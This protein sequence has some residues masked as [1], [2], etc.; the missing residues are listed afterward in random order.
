M[1]NQVSSMMP[2]VCVGVVAGSSLFKR[3]YYETETEHIESCGGTEPFL[4]VGWANTAGYKPFPGL[5]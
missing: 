5:W 4:R 1:R 3:W 2:N